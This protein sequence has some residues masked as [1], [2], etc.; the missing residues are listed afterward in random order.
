MPRFVPIGEEDPMST[1]CRM[2]INTSYPDLPGNVVNFGKYSILD[3]IGITIGGSAMEGIPA[4]V[5]LVKSKGGKPESTIPLYGGK[6]PASEAALAIAPMARAMDFGQVHDEGDHCSEYIVPALLAATGLKDKVTGRELLTAFTVG[7]E[8]LLRIG[9]AFRADSRGAPLGRECGHFIFGVVAAVGKLL[10]LSQDEL[11][12]AEGIARTMT[13]PHDMAMYAP[14]TLMVRVHHGF[15]CQNGIN[16][17]LLAKR[18]ITGPRHEVLT[19]PKGYLGFAK[20]ETDPDALTKGLGEEW[21]ML[22][23][24]IKPY[25]SCKGIHT[26]IEGILTQMKEHNFKAEDIANIEID[27]GSG[28]WFFACQPKEVMWN[29][30]TVAECQFSM[31]YL[32]ATAA[33][34]G[35]V[36]LDSYTPQARARKDVRELMTRITAKENP[37]LPLFGARINTTLNNGKKY[38]KEC[39]YAKGSSQNPLTE[40]ELVNKFKGCVPYS[41]YKL[42]DA[43]V[44]SLIGVLLNLEE[45]DD[46]ANALILRLT[47]PQ[48]RA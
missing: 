48:R 7:Q 46:I 6:V 33:Y 43:V 14:A 25:P 32:V 31:P 16:A 42:S 15:V 9:I 17:C 40:Q 4:V 34:D 12:N 18:G 22:N 24:D 20:W 45:V 21:E 10:G 1:L 38:S 27:E 47:P 13:G 5:D 2:V 39:L 8:V 3:A 19:G 44:D 35:G 23:A 28:N 30:Q 26:S 37:S 29:P 11:E 36:S 41:A